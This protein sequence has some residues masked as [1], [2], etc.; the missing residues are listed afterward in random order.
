MNQKRYFLVSGTIFGLVA[1]LHCIRAINQWPFELGLWM[2]P[3]WISWLGFVAAGA[4]SVW[5]FRFASR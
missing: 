5:A 1:L 2:V 4:L 3:V